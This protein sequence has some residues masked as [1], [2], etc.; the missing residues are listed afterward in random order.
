MCLLTHIFC[1]TYVD[2]VHAKEVR[3]KYSNSDLHFDLRADSLLLFHS[4]YV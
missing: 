2:M 3:Y 4:S 1:Y